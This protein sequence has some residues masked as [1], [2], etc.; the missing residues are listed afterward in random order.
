MTRIKVCGIK[1]PEHAALVADLG[2]EFLGLVFAA[3]PRMVT[4]HK[5]RELAR[6]LSSLKSKP[7]TVGVFVDVKADEVNRIAD[8]CNLDWVQLSGSETWE[9]CHSMERPV[10]KAIKVGSSGERNIIHE[11]ILRGRQGISNDR[12]ILLLDAKVN[13]LFG[14]SGKTFD[15]NLIPDM[16]SGYRA[17]IAGG[18][19]PL[20]VGSL[21]EQ[22]HPWGVD[23]SSGVEIGGK[24]DAVKIRSFVKKVRESSQ[25]E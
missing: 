1:E 25:H 17:M 18:L 12:L 2:V 9:Y 21:I 7:S 10:I 15:W 6:T 11:D 19:E 8:Y 14:G 13:G 23:V 3:S 24:K 4:P 20:N 16:P 5:A 22:K